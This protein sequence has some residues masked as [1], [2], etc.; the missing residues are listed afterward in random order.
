MATSAFVVFNEGGIQPAICPEEARTMAIPLPGG[1]DWAAGTVLAQLT[2]VTQQNEVQTVTI[3]GTPTGGTFTL[4]FFGQTTSAIAYNA[5][6]SAVQ[7]ALLALD[8]LDTGDVVVTGGPGPGTPYVLTFGG[9]LAN[10]DVPAVTATGSFT[11][12]TN[13]AIAVAET[14]KGNPGAAYWAPYVDG[15][16]EPARVILKYRTRTN[17]DGTLLD[18]QGGAGAQHTTVYFAGVFDT[19]QLTGIDANGVADMGRLITG[20]TGSL[21]TAGTL[22]RM[23]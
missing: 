15:S 16:V 14:T 12:G 21:S 5:A 18:P 22:L 19:S 6:A 7:T 9:A 11:G 8:W 10:R 1:I 3:T 23:G 13:P 20:A 4:T 17:P 2:A